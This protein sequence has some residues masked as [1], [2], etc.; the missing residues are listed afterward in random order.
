MVKLTHMVKSVAVI[1]QTFICGQKYNTIYG[2]PML[3]KLAKHN[4]LQNATDLTI[5][6][7]L[8]I[9]CNKL[10]HYIQVCQFCQHQN[11]LKL[12]IVSALIV[13]QHN[14]I[15]SWFVT[16]GEIRLQTV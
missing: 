14:W 12:V 15:T 13:K 3:T 1:D 9:I 16:I 6:M 4:R 5:R 7:S 8:T 11:V 10:E 2:I